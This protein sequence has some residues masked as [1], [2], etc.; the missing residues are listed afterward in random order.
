MQ[1]WLKQWVIR[2]LEEALRN[3]KEDKC[4]MSEMEMQALF[5]A[6]ADVKMNKHQAAGMLNLSQSSFENEIASGKI[7]EGKKLYAGDT[8]K[9][10]TK[11]DLI[12]YLKTWR[13]R[14]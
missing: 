7:P 5:D 11:R 6:L 10:W 4:S 3:I 1:N 9:Y 14:K 2:L 12:L 13:K 8:H